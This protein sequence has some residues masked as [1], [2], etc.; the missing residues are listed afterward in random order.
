MYILQFLI[1]YMLYRVHKNIYF[2]NLVY[3]Y[4]LTG[5]SGGAVDEDEDHAAEGPSDAE[6]SDSVALV[7][8]SYDLALVSDD[9]E[10]RDVQKQHGRY[11]L[12]DDSSVK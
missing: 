11:E 5:D 12:G 3:M 9:C 4:V 10:N 1:S 7:S 6:D 8:F 2:T